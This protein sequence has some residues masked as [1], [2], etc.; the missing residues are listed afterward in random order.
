M[1]KVAILG[2]GA[3]GTVIGALMAR[4]GHL[5]DM[6]DSY[7]DHVDALNEKG[8][9][10]IGTENFT[11]PVKAMLPEQMEG[12]Y[13]V[14]FLITKQT[15]NKEVLGRLLPHLG[16]DSVVCT[17]QN[18]M[19]EHFVGELVGHDRT[20]SGTMLWGATFMGPGVSKAT[21]DLPAKVR[22]GSPFFDVGEPNGEITDRIKMVAEILEYT[23]G[24]VEIVTD[25]MY[26][27]WRKIAMNC[28]GSGMSAA[29]GCTFHDVAVDERGMEC[30]TMIGYEVLQCA[31]AAGYD[32]SPGQIEAFSDPNGKGRKFFADAYWEGSRGTGKASMLQD[33]EK[34]KI[35]EVDM[36]NGYV[37]GVGDK[38]GIDTPYNDAVVSIVHR[39]EKGELPL[40]LSNLQYFPD[41]KYC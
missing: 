21:H 17:M 38:Y 7:K 27:R 37:C 1:K 3:M 31:R 36:I 18:G 19:P 8:A 30:L 4:N 39:M 6:V 35:T 13:D 2:C 28:T 16:P 15:A 40:S 24:K 33:L 5:V 11:V 25:M 10:I 23:G 34:G 22:R 32:L 26:A 14:V 9:T 12:I 20:V 41:I 29:C